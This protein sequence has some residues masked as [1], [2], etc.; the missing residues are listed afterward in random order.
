[1]EESEFHGKIQP[2][3]EKMSMESGKALKE[4]ATTLKNMR[5][6][7]SNVAVHLNNSMAAAEELKYIM[8]NSSLHTEPDLNQILP[9]LV[10]ASILVDVV[11]FVEKISVS[12]HKLSEKACFKEL[13]LQ[14]PLLLHRGIVKP[15]DDEVVVEIVEIP[16]NSS[17]IKNLS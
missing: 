1:M 8:E 14:A 5:A 7:S 16:S 6:P 12:V 4:L 9:I 17:E 10:V 3:C 11:Q 15:L 2:L 13:K